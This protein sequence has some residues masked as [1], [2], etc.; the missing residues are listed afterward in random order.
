MAEGIQIFDE[1]NRL[2]LDMSHTLAKFKKTYEFNNAT[3][4]QIWVDVLDGE[5]SFFLV[6]NGSSNKNI[7]L[8]KV[9][10]NSFKVSSIGYTRIAFGTYKI[11]HDLIQQ[12]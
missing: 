12:Y 5:D 7:S 3:D 10:N 9:S 11:R 2:T 4:H 8:V 6:L 1:Q